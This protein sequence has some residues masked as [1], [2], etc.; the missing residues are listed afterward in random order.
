M[1]KIILALA[2]VAMPTV[3]V[4]ANINSQENLIFSPKSVPDSQI[5]KFF[6]SESFSKISK[7]F[8]V[9]KE[10]FDLKTTEVIKIDETSNLIRLKVNNGSRI[11]HIMLMPNNSIVLYEKTL[12]N[13]NGN[14]N[15]EQYDDNG[16]LIANFDV[17]KEAGKYNVKLNFI[18]PATA[19][20]DQLTCVRKT[21][22]YIKKNCDKDTTCSISCDLS[23]QCATIMYGVAIAHC[24]A[25]GNKPP[26]EASYSLE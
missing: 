14:G 23:P 7:N 22:N 20:T 8:N 2:F 6:N 4:L 21:Y 25:S 19:L 11:D 5:E 18:S 26:K 15:I 10:N 24:A 16:T 12:I 1:K 9:K 13:Q 3:T 17:K